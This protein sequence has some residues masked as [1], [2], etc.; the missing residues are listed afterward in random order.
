MGVETIINNLVKELMQE[1]RGRAEASGNQFPSEE[2]P[3][4]S[5]AKEVDMSD[6]NEEV[7]TAGKNTFQNLMKI[8]ELADMM[9]IN[10]RDIMRINK[11]EG[12]E[13]LAQKV[14]SKLS[15][16]LAM[17]IS[18]GIFNGGP[19]RGA[20]R[21][22]P[23]AFGGAFG[24]APSM[25]GNPMGNMLG[26]MGFKEAP[27]EEEDAGRVADFAKKCGGFFF[28]KWC[29]KLY[30]CF[31]LKFLWAKICLKFLAIKCCAKFAF[32]RLIKALP[33]LIFEFFFDFIVIFCVCKLLKLKNLLADTDKNDEEMSKVLKAI[34][35]GDG[36]DDEGYGT[37]DSTDSKDGNGGGGVGSTVSYCLFIALIFALF[38][39]LVK[40][41]IILLVSFIKCLK[42]FKGGYGYGGYG[43][44]GYGRGFGYGGYGRGYHGYGGCGGYGYG[45]CGYGGCGG[46][47]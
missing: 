16:D 43:G 10:L 15:M 27:A 13:Q 33:C 6:I 34:A 23:G 11:L 9:G 32:K 20:P 35:D 47:C 39:L 31:G 7:S 18:S 42:C 1:S 46:C 38:L 36:E 28:F 30:Y 5:F 24:G 2:A 26:G 37:D 22:P 21:G 29:K 4:F 44:Y 3:D 40:I 8:K 45:G 17:A 14:A 19:G 25:G 41:V 12:L